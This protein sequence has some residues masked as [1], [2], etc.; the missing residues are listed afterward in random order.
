MNWTTITHRLVLFE[1]AA[2]ESRQNVSFQLFAL[3]AQRT[4]GTTVVPPAK[5]ANH[6]ED[7]HSLTIKTSFPLH[8]ENLYHIWKETGKRPR[9]MDGTNTRITSSAPEGNHLSH[10]RNFYIFSYER[11]IKYLFLFNL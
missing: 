3:T 1:R 6:L 8:S 11:V 5:K 9:Q 7:G 10:N 2:L 4:L